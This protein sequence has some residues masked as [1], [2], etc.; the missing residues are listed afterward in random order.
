MATY[1]VTD[2]EDRDKPVNVHEGCALLPFTL[3]TL[4]DPVKLRYTIGALL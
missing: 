3:I 1:L 4:G 2:R